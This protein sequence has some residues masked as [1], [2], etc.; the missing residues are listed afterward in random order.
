MCGQNLAELS[1]VP[2][3]SRLLPWTIY[4]PHYSFFFTTV[5]NPSKIR[6]SGRRVH[7]F[8]S[9]NF[10]RVDKRTT[11]LIAGTGTAISVMQIMSLLVVI[12]KAGTTIYFSLSSMQ[13][14]VQ[15]HL[16]ML[17]G[18][19]RPFWWRILP[20]VQICG[21]EETEDWRDSRSL[22]W[23][24]VDTSTESRCRRDVLLVVSFCRYDCRRNW[25]GC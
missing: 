24:S 6:M 8:I 21:A 7:P 18:R 20:R 12:L 19:L 1:E 15:M 2:N 9:N 10:T 25:L 11:C 5:F 13:N 23:P 14:C 3:A 22:H 16:Q 4:I 17:V